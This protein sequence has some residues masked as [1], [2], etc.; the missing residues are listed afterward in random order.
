[1][2]IYNMKENN[3]SNK[4]NLVWDQYRYSKSIILLFAPG[5][6]NLTL[7]FFFKIAKFGGNLGIFQNDV[8]AKP[9]NKKWKNFARR[10][11]SWYAFR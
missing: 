5:W 2:I 1:M 7:L 4:D 10:N 9:F 3:I 6:I 8:E 11:C